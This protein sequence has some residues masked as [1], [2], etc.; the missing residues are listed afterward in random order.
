MGHGEQ[1]DND[2]TCYLCGA[3]GELLLCDGCDQACHLRC[4]GLRAIPA[5]DW[6]CRVCIDEDAREDAG[7]DE[8]DEGDEGEPPSQQRQQN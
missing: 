1:D 7:E 5:D 6:F 3:G 2:D 4:I 8:E